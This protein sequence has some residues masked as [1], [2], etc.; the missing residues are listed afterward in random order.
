MPAGEVNGIAPLNFFESKFHV[1][2]ELI[3][4]KQVVAP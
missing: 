1:E 2:R 3:E 4:W